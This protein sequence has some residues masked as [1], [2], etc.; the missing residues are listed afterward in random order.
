M[1]SGNKVAVYIN[2][3]K[4]K[5]NHHQCQNILFQVIAIIFSTW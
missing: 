1:T 4:I 2:E 5:I 3:L